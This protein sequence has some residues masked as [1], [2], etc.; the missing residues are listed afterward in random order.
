MAEP[1]ALEEII[2]TTH[3]KYHIRVESL[4]NADTH[5]MALTLYGHVNSE[6]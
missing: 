3:R 6:G 5:V 4:I 1:L 2:V